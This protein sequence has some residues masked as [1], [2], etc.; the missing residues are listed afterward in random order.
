MYSYF[1]DCVIVIL[2]S[3]I[4]SKVLEIVLQVVISFG[5]FSGSKVLKMFYLSVKKNVS[6]FFPSS[7]F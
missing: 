5:F 7:S 6:D 3:Q 1:I 4:Q 2:Y